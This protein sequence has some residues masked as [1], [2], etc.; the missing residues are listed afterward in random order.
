MI[1]REFLIRYLIANGFGLAVLVVAF[2]RP[3][4]ARWLGVAVFV[5][6]AATNAITSLTHPDVYVD[7]ATLTPSGLY[8]DFILGW[9][10]Q[11]VQLMVLPIAVGQ[12][13][14]AG[15]LA[16]PRDLHRRLG[17]YGAMVFL[18][19]IAPLGVGAGF[20]FSL[21]F[22]VTLL[23]S[24]GTLRVTSP[25]VQRVLW[26]SPRVFGLGLCVFLGLFALDA[27]SSQKAAVS[28]PSAGSRDRPCKTHCLCS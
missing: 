26:W 28:P 23:V 27:F 15:L 13:I 14:I 10:R 20:P 6:A 22:S 19:A 11:H 5:W 25:R 8:R 16:F 7:Y 3:R 12:L 2:W 9:F 4:I 21:T 24:Q 17:V 1:P 18:L